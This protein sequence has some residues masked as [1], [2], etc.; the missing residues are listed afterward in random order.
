MIL[1][2]GVNLRYNISMDRQHVKKSSP[3]LRLPDE[4]YDVLREWADREH[5]SF[6]G[7]VTHLLVEAIA[8]HRARQVMQTSGKGA[9]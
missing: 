5:R 6:N 7:H 4:M 8:Q 3:G 2:L 9:K 1:A